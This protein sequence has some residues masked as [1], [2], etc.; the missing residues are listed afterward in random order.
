MEF[1]RDGDFFKGLLI[2]TL[3]SVPLWISLIG[4]IK[5]FI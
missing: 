1:Q 5:I 2:A 3:F 4:W